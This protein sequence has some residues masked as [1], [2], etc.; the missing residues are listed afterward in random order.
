MVEGISL[1]QVL[2]SSR[3]DDTGDITRGDHSGC[4][5]TTSS[6][7]PLRKKMSEAWTTD[8][9]LG[10]FPNSSSPFAAEAHSTGLSTKPR[11]P[12]SMVVRERYHSSKGLDDVRIVMR[13]EFE[14]CQAW[15]K[16]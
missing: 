8:V 12:Y 6:A 3:S 7:A 2:R 11:R 13:Q 9:D 15:K 10:L 1:H 16:V 5:S 4:C 14:S